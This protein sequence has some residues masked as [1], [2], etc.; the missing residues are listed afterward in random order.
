MKGKIILWLK[1][2]GIAGFLF[3]PI[4]GLIW[5]AILLGAGTLI[6]K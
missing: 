4:K 1:R 3:F 2:L 6:F 5:L